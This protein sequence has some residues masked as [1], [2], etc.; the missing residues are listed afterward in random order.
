MSNQTYMRQEV[1]AIPGVVANFLD[2]S[3]PVL[4]AAAAALRERNPAL[5]ATVTR[6]S[7]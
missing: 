7:V 5:V 4:D 1:E 3:G 2:Q 6:W